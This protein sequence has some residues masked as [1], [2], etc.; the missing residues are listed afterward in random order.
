[1][2]HYLI[3]ESVRFVV[4][5]AAQD[6][7]LRSFA[8]RAF[9]HGRMKD[10][11]GKLGKPTPDHP[12]LAPLIAASGGNPIELQSIARKFVN[13]Q[14]MRQEADYD[15][16]QRFNRREALNAIADVENAMESWEAFKIANPSSLSGLN[17]RAGLRQR[18]EWW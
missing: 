17:Q 11:C 2:F 16:S 18:G 10:L 7:D 1:L 6:S 12:L 14:Q 15:L 5:S 4:G 13:L 3:D 9:V 8:S